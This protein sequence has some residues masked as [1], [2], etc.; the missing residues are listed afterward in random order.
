MKPKGGP[1]GGALVTL[2]HIKNLAVQDF[3]KELKL[4]NDD[5]IEA[6][7]EIEEDEIIVEEAEN[8]N[9]SP[10]GKLKKLFIKLKY[11]EQLRHK[12]QCSCIT[13]NTR[14]MSPSNDVK[15]RW[16]STDDIIAKTLRMQK[17]IILL[18]I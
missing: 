14:M 13:T 8:K 16:H 18:C 17:A 11:S 5:E 4:L 6:N 7:Y 9:H 10:I 15:R 3:L 2:K 12:L 1:A